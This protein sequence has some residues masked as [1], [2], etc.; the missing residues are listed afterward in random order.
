MEV[1]KVRIK[2]AFL[3]ILIF[4]A[5][6]IHKPLVVEASERD[7]NDRLIK[8][9]ITE[10]VKVEATYDN[11]ETDTEMKEDEDLKL[12]EELD[13]ELDGEEE[14]GNKEEQGDEE[15]LGNDEELGVDEEESSA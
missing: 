3:L 1:K 9:G 15:V 10:N 5:L 6:Y 7:Y 14:K 13:E 12:G 4:S 2:D 11:K 8:E